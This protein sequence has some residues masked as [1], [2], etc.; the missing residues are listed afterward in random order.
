MSLVPSGN[1]WCESSKLVNTVVTILA[2]ILLVTPGKEFCSCTTVGT[3][4][5]A[6]LNN[7][8]PLTYPPVP[9]TISGL[10]FLTTFLDCSKP[11]N[12]LKTLL[13][14]SK[15]IFLLNPWTV[16]VFSS[17]PYLGTISDSIPFSVPTNN[18]SA[19][20]FS[21][22]ILFAMAIAGY[23]CPPVPPPDNKTFI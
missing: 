20:G 1:L 9:I 12:S 22:F 19:S 15:S 5:I 2:S 23:T 18:I 16:T 6:A 21:S 3:L 10:N 8:G 11:L 17:Y 14:L 7:T 13:T 4:L